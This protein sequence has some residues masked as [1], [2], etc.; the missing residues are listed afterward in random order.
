MFYEQNKELFLTRRNLIRDIEGLENDL[1]ECGANYEELERKVKF[2]KENCSS[3]ASKSVLKDFEK[4]MG[5]ISTSCISGKLYE[6]KA[7]LETS[8]KHLLCLINE[9]LNVNIE[10]ELSFM[11]QKLINWVEAREYNLSCNVKNE[12]LVRA[13]EQFYQDN[14]TFHILYADKGSNF[15]VCESHVINFVCEKFYVTDYAK[16]PLYSDFNEMFVRALIRRIKESFETSSNLK[17]I[18]RVE[19]KEN[20]GF[21]LILK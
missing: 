9:V 1:K 4:R 6:K 18:F 2:I 10:D 8:E 17:D 12:F 19:I 20:A 16:S 13:W 7:S 21:Y 3:E 5:L 11:A 14:L 15:E